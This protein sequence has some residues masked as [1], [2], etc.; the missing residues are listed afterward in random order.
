MLSPWR[1]HTL[2]LFAGTW[3]S[4]S[5]PHF[6]G[7]RM[8]LKRDWVLWLYNSLLS[9]VSLQ[10]M[11]CRSQQ[12]WSASILDLRAHKNQHRHTQINTSTHT[13]IQTYPETHIHTHTST[14]AITHPCWNTN[15]H[16]HIQI[17]TQT[18]KQVFR[19]TH[20]DADLLFIQ[21]TLVYVCDLPAYMHVKTYIHACIHANTNK[22][23][24]TVFQ[25][26]PIWIQIHAHIRAHTLEHKHRT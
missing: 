21:N 10:L 16:A 1:P 9:R 24:R 12:S 22:N 25:C 20:R 15:V 19:D 8:G 26:H 5:S 7:L 3:V 17:H 18:H 4:V 11:H 6:S 14:Q 2:L 13:S 23:W